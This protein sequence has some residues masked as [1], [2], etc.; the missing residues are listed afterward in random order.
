MKDAPGAHAMA[1]SIQEG[2]DGK[3][4]D[5]V[6]DI[7]HA[8]EGEYT[9]AQYAKVLRRADWILLPLM[10]IVS[11]T[12]YADKVSVSTQATFGLR[13]D[14]GLVGQ[15]Y[16]C[17]FQCTFVTFLHCHAPPGFGTK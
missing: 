8:A 11:G 14:T 4:S 12:Q 10:W 16:S 6:A 7:V 1:P 5:V 13:T 2:G 3:A 9:A 15:Q 17:E